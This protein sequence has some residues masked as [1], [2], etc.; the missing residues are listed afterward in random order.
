MT[1]LRANFRINGT[2]GVASG[3]TIFTAI[4]ETSVTQTA[5]LTVAVRAAMNGAT[6]LAWDFGDGTPILRTVP[7]GTPPAIPPA[8]GTHTYATP[9]RYVIK[10]RCVQNDSLSEFRISVS[11]SRNQK[12][13]DPLIIGLPRFTL[14]PTTKA[15]TITTGGSVQQ[16]GRILW[17]VGDLSAEGNS[18]T[19]TLKPG[20]YTLD[21]AAVR[22][23]NFRAYGARRFVN[24][25]APLPLRG[26]SATTNRTFDLNDNETN[27]TGAPPLPARNELA[28]RL[29]DK[30]AI[31]PEDD[32]TF[33]LIP[34]EILGLPAGTAIGAEELDLSE[35]QD[36]VLSMEYEIT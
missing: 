21:F 3:I 24:G 7:G 32:W 22:K 9:G 1:R 15:I 33:E 10:L 25:A 30:G 31:S 13:G 27:G 26:L 28:K 2:G 8:E 14:N 11:V 4:P 18:A 16:A 29:F 23:L 34:E 17:R 19:F 36:V 5:P 6:E 35:I 20:N 12:L